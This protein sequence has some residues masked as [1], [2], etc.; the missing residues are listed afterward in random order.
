MQDQTVKDF[1]D[2]LLAG[3]QDQAY[4]FINNLPY[5]HLV[6]LLDSVITPA[7]QYIGDLWEKNRVSVADEHLATAICDFILAKLHPKT[8]GYKGQTAMFMCLEGESH[9]IGLK[10][11]SMLFAEN[12]W[13]IR[14]LGPNMPVEH[15]LK[16]VE[17]IKP[18]V[19][20]L[21]VTIAYHLPRIA[22]YLKGLASLSERPD[23]IIG[24]RLALQHDFSLYGVQPSNVM[25]NLGDVTQWM[26]GLKQG[27][28]VNV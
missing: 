21:S 22:A 12:G 5:R 25:K 4:E 27:E 10:M 6:D 16:Q 14:Y 9:Y 18:D 8:E 20:C 26:A 3:N 13:R 23:V 2:L 1:A 7:L 11:A 28:R 19:V 17:D 15:V 24:S